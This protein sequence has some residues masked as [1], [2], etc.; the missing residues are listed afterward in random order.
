[1]PSAYCNRHTQ[2]NIVYMLN[3]VVITWRKSVV[4]RTLASFAHK[5]ENKIT[6]KKA[7]E[8]TKLC[9]FAKMMGKSLKNA[10]RESFIAWQQRAASNIAATLIEMYGQSHA[11]VPLVHRSTSVLNSNGAAVKFMDSLLRQDN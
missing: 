2:I 3:S 8:K 4:D 9:A 6:R 10:L 11:L 5:N 1:M 7:A